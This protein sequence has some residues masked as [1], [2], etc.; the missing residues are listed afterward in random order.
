MQQL[1]TKIGSALAS[2]L[3]GAT[4]TFAQQAGPP[5]RSQTS[6]NQTRQQ[7]VSALPANTGATTPY[8]SNA[9]GLAQ[10]AYLTPISGLQG[11]LA[12]T[13]DGVTLA[14][15]SIDDRFNPASSV[16]LATALVALQTFGPGHR[17][18]TSIWASGQIDKS[19][20]TLN[21]D[22]I[23][24]GRDPSLHYEHAVMLARELNELG[25]RSVTGNLIVAPGFTMNFDWSPKH[26]GEEFRETLDAARRSGAATRA[27]L[28]ERT[29][30]GDRESL[31][32]VPSV[33]ISGEVI[34]GSAP[35]GSVPLLTHKSSKLV[36]VLKVLLCYSNNFMAERIGENL[37]GP[38]TISARVADTLKI[39]PAEIFLSSTSGLGV[40]RV[41][42]RAMMK[43]LRALSAELQKNKLVLS[44]ILPVAGIDP[45][46]L[47]ERYTDQVSRGSVI[48]KTGTLVRT[49]GGASSLVGEMKTKSG[50]VVLFVILNQRGSVVRFRQN[51]DQI[52]TAI[53]N[54]LG[55]PAPF[56]YV[57][58][59]LPTRLADSDYETAKTRGE[60][61][62][63]NQQ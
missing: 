16:K 26:S 8:S 5:D 1:L 9:P 6:P 36:D 29:L 54:T 57:P 53:Q 39:S 37:G 47:E 31:R 61:E 48:A 3:I 7:A 19:T 28:D 59:K 20:G 25:V 10:P 46:T 33:V 38:Q 63:R 49:D 11:V 27:W 42:P 4:F 52:V 15:Q 41:T 21:G 44:D 60:Y 14:A 18:L 56:E 50:R 24:T 23:V 30:V 45:G 58:V 2:V 43:I 17:F 51:Q 62:P 32:S 12:E 13:V 22:L 40:N 34:V 55:G 35:T